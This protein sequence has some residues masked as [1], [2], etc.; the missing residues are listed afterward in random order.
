MGKVPD[1]AFSTGCLMSYILTLTTDSRYK[2]KVGTKETGDGELIDVFVVGRGCKAP[3][4][5]RVR[6]LWLLLLAR[7]VPHS[8]LHLTRAAGAGHV[9]HQGH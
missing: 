3:V 7:S 1:A 2:K 5:L 8:P 6:A 9:G 4:A